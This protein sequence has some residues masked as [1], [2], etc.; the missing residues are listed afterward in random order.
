MQLV[1]FALQLSFGS[2]V[3]YDGRR[4]NYVE[5]LVSKVWNLNLNFKY[6]DTAAVHMEMKNNVD[7]C[8]N[9]I[10]ASQH[11]NANENSISGF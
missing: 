10:L 6:N 11:L 9:N 7:S 3:F 2:L 1:E 4:G 5:K 8:Y